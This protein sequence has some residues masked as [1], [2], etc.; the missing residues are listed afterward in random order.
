MYSN[1]VNKMQVINKVCIPRYQHTRE[2]QQCKWSVKSTYRLI[3]HVFLCIVYLIHG[4]VQKTVMT[5]C[6]CPMVKQIWILSL[7][8]CLYCF[9]FYKSNSVP[10]WRTRAFTS[11]HRRA[12]CANHGPFLFTLFFS[13]TILQKNC[14]SQQD[15]NSDRQSELHVWVLVR[16]CH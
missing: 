16:V 1:S 4:T 7:N 15:S 11:H 2:L 12:L 13:T 8:N 6:V 5:A 10:L 3:T 14:R 9:D